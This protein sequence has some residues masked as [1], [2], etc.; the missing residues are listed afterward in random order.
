MYVPMPKLSNKMNAVCTVTA[1]KFLRILSFYLFWKHL[2]FPRVIAWSLR[3]KRKLL[4]SR[5]SESLGPSCREVYQEGE[6]FSL[7]G[8]LGTVRWWDFWG[9]CVVS[10]GKCLSTTDLSGVWRAE[11]WLVDGLTFASMPWCWTIKSSRWKG[12]MI[13]IWLQCQLMK[14]QLNT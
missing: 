8:L 13:T 14:V 3:M 11:L 6:C 7:Q 2:A 10:G 4:S 5:A 1:A 9:W 12:E